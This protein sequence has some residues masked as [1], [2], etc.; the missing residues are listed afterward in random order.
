MME[1]MPGL[2]L[3]PVVVIIFYF[4]FILIKEQSKK[5]VKYDN[6]VKTINVMDAYNANTLS[7]ATNKK[8]FS[9]KYGDLLDSINKYIKNAINKGDYV[10]H[11]PVKKDDIRAKELIKFLESKKY[12]VN[13]IE[14][15]SDTEFN[16]LR[17][18]WGDH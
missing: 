12:I 17:I 16:D 8:I 4:M 13:Y 6:F 14:L 3:V 7:A 15:N 1:Y 10:C 2:L 5:D 18:Y 11:V 9:E